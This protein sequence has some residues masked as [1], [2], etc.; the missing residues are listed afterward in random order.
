MQK[1]GIPVNCL[2]GWKAIAVFSYSKAVLLIINGC[3]VWFD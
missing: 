2:E 1:K 3:F